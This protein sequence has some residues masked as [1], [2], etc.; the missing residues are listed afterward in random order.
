MQIFA[1]TIWQIEHLSGR[2]KSAKLNFSVRV[3][4]ISRD[5]RSRACS[6]RLRRS[7]HILGGLGSFVRS[8]FLLQSA[9]ARLATKLIHDRQIMFAACK[10]QNVDRSSA[11]ESS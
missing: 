5:A 3:A 1:V 4:F 7:H 9:R 8:I 2:R 11:S 10:P 6:V